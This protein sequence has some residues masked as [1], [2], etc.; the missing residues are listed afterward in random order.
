MLLFYGLVFLS[1]RKISKSGFKIL[2]IRFDEMYSLVLEASNRPS[3][4]IF[5][6]RHYS[7]NCINEKSLSYNPV[8][9][10]LAERFSMVLVV[11]L[12]VR[13]RVS[14]SSGRWM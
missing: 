9:I 13:Y 5:G 6:S 2:V 10:V 8:N 1:L 3:T 4:V 7:E 14:S 11:L 12:E